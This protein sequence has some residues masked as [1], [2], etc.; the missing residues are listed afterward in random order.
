MKTYPDYT[1]ILLHNG[2]FFSHIFKV[3]A[4]KIELYFYHI[5]HTLFHLHMSH[6]DQNT[7]TTRNLAFFELLV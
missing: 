1:D 5:L 3:E 7:V 4:S 6:Y 2:H